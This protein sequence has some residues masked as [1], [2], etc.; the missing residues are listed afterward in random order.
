MVSAPARVIVRLF[1]AVMPPAT[2]ATTMTSPAD[3]ADAAGNV[4]VRAAVS[5][6][7]VTM[8]RVD[9]PIVTSA[10]P[11]VAKPPVPMTVQAK[12]PP[13]LLVSACVPSLAQ[14]GT[15]ASAGAAADPVKFP[16]TVEV[17]ILAI[18]AF[19]TALLAMVAAPAAEIVRSVPIVR[20]VGAAP[21]CPTSSWPLVIAAVATGAAPAPPP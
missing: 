18:F 3:R 1:A 6:A 11:C 21:V 7:L 10:S 8:V 14:D 9:V 15:E 5:A 17:A 19:V 13:A 12:P 2:S 20:G 4:Q 16:F